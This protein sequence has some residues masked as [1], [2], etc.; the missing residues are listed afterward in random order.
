MKMSWASRRSAHLD[1]P[2]TDARVGLDAT[3]NLPEVD[4]LDWR[5]CGLRSRARRHRGRRVD[6]TEDFDVFGRIPRRRPDDP[7]GVHRRP[8]RA[9]PEVAPMASTPRLERLSL[10][11]RRHG[12]MRCDA[13]QDLRR[14]RSR[15]AAAVDLGG[16]PRTSRRGG[17]GWRPLA[18]SIDRRRARRHLPARDA[19]RGTV[20]SVVC[21]LGG[22]GC[23]RWHARDRRTRPTAWSRRPSGIARAAGRGASGGSGSIPAAVPRASISRGLA[24]ADDRFQGATMTQ[25]PSAPAARP[26]SETI[27]L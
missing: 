13:G 17:P 24:D 15:D 25:V 4:Q 1:A 21:P 22:P 27:G 20:R 11:T 19:G 7:A 9:L 8:G 23:R 10:K 18:G 5:C 14:Q 16:P 26:R 3:L 2:E 12:S 6:P